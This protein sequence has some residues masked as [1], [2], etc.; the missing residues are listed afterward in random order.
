MSRILSILLGIS[1]I[2]CATSQ[3]ISSQKIAEKVNSSVKNKMSLGQA[4]VELSKLGFVCLEGTSIEPNQ[5][6]IYECIRNRSGFLY[7]CIDK[8]WFEAQSNDGPISNLKVHEPIC[9]S[10]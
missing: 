7:S 6:D 5:K 2:G 4:Q 1:L 8:V 3:T 10:L 9:A